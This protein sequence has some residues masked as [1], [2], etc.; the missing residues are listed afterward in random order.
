MTA[1]GQTTTGVKER[2]A[3]LEDFLGQNARK[4]DRKLLITPA[5]KNVASLLQKVR[6]FVK[7]NAGVT[8]VNMI[9]LLNPIIRSWASFHWHVLAK[10]RFT[11]LDHQVWK[12]LWQWAS[13]R[14]PM[15]SASWVQNKY[16]KIIWGSN[17]SSLPRMGCPAK[18]DPFP[19]H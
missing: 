3:P 5:N 9:R 2:P 14:H 13:R 10:A 19:Y 11:W 16:C 8:Q 18:P 4:Y 6:T 1:R 7:A 12:L 15:K 17:G